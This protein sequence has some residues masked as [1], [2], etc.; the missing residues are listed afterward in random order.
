[1]TVRWSTVFLSPTRYRPEASGL[2]A[3]TMC[4]RAPSLMSQSCRHTARLQGGNSAAWLWAV[5]RETVH[6][7][8]WLS[9]AHA[10]LLAPD[11]AEQVT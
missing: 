3:A 10:V 5:H 11:T 4:A 1:M 6:P 2:S 8:S 9:S 7:P